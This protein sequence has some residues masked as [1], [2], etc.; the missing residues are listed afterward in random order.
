MLNLTQRSKRLIKEEWQI[1]ILKQLL[2][3]DPMWTKDT[4]ILAIQKTGLDAD[5]VYK[6]GWDQLKKY[7]KGSF[8]LGHHM[9]FNN[10]PGVVHNE[11]NT[12]CSSVN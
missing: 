2:K 12:A 8:E 5:K 10:Y 9:S 11:V 6:W 3:R 1:Q 4:Q 7:K